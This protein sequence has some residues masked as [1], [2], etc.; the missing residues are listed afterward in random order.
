MYYNMMVQLGNG[1]SETECEASF[2]GFP[3][4]PLHCLKR[5]PRR[6]RVAHWLSGPSSQADEVSQPFPA[7]HRLFTQA[8][9]LYKTF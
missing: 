8:A 2:S 4:T 1:V 5:K 6:T 3:S 7:K 9:V